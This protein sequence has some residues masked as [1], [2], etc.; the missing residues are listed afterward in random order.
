[1]V[2]EQLGKRVRKWPLLVCALLLALAVTAGT[3][4][5]TQAATIRFNMARST[6]AVTDDCIASARASVTVQEL[7]FAERLT[8]RASGLP[9]NTGFDVFIIQVPDAPFGLSWY[10]G[11]F[12]TNSRGRATVTFVG[13]FNIETFIVAPGVAPAPVTHPGDAAQ[14][15]ATAPVHLYHIGIWFDDPNDAETA[16]CSNTTTPFNGDHTAGIQALSTRNFGA[17]DG[18]LNQL[19]P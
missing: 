13:R 15:P 5:I 8:I 4:N 17:G 12:E 18:P 10:Q 6:Q 19:A 14:N 1:M 16:G 9:R 7:G 3:A 11:D 2:A